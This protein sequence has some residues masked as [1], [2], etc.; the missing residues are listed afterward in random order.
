MKDLSHRLSLEFS[1][2][3][4]RHSTF[5]IRRKNFITGDLQT[6]VKDLRIAIVGDSKAKKNKSYCSMLSNG[7]ECCT[8]L[9][10]CKFIH[11]VP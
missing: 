2:A 1:G 3:E 10:W 5:T 9:V 8:M 7:Q 4:R 6:T 11:N